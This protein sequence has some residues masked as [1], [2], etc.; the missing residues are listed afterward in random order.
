MQQRPAEVPTFYPAQLVHNLALLSSMCHFELS[1]SSSY[2]LSMV[3]ST[4]LIS[5]LSSRAFYILKFCGIE[6]EAHFKALVIME[7]VEMV[8]VM[9]VVFNDSKLTSKRNL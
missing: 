1:F 4:L 9:E 5:N 8:E 6:M 2:I 7:V 3:T